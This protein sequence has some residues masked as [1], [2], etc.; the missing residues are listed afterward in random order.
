[1]PPAKSALRFSS[2]CCGVIVAPM[3]SRALRTKSTAWRVV[4]CSN[5]M[6][7]FG[8]RLRHRLEHRVD[9]ARFAIEHVDRSGR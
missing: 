2:R 4:M 5:T 6:R 9:E 8:K 7:S 1:M 3:P